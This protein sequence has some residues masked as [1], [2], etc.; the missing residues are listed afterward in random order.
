VTDF[1]PGDHVDLLHPD[2]TVYAQGVIL[3]EPEAMRFPCVFH[4]R[5]SDATCTEWANVL[6]DLTGREAEPV[7]YYA[8][9]V[10]ECR[11]RLSDFGQALRDA[12]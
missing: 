7:N 11:M 1:Q 6:L 9:H 12:D 8:Y 3:Y 2:G 4:G 5:D 10:G